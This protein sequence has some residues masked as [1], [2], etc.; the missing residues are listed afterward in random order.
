MIKYF[1]RCHKKILTIK[2]ILT[3]S[4]FIIFKHRKPD[5]CL[6]NSK[7]RSL[8]IPYMIIFKPPQY[9]SIDIHV[10]KIQTKMTKDR[11]RSHFRF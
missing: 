9:L 3:I 6:G 2:Q 4:L 1:T 8:K 11:T 5:G 7:L 10:I